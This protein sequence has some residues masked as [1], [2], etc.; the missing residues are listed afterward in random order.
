M[1]MPNVCV[2]LGASR[3]L[4]VLRQASGACRGL[5]VLSEA[6]CMPRAVGLEASHVY[7]EG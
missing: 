7:A 2:K 3:E 6:W 4:R 1:C 5:K